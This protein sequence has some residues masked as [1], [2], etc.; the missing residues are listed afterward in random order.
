VTASDVVRR[1]V[2]ELREQQRLTYVELAER[3]GQVGSPI[4]VLGLRRIERGERRVDVDEL[5]A[6]A[7]V[8]GVQLAELLTA[9]K[10][11]AAQTTSDRVAERVRDLRRRGGW[12]SI[13]AFAARCAEVG[14]PYL[15]AAALMNLE[16]GRCK[17]GRRTRAITVDELVVL[18]RALGVSPTDLLDT[19]DMPH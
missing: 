10:S 5:L 4:P 17:D 16:S 9:P 13:K 6:L 18:A 15:T 3:L 19:E 11:E 12:F 14:P 1:R 8:L 7:E 2:K